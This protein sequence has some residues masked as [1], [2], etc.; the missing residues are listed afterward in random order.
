VAQL[1]G[2]AAGADAGDGGADW[3][4][5]RRSTRLPKWAAACRHWTAADRRWLDRMAV[6]SQHHSARAARSPYWAR[7]LAPEQVHPAAVHSGPAV[8]DRHSDAV[9]VVV[10]RG[11]PQ[12][13][14][15]AAKKANAKSFLALSL[16]CYRRVGNRDAAAEERRVFS[17]VQSS[18]VLAA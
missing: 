3:G 16:A 10:R 18:S 7:P 8:A 13:G 6:E 15:N 5:R 2:P 1:L 4:R 12:S 17:S 11:T 14:R 9:A